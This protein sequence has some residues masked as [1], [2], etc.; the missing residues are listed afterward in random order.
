MSAAQ[1]LE[2]LADPAL[3]Q[4]VRTT[5]LVSDRELGRLARHEHWIESGSRRTGYHP[6]I[7]H[8]LCQSGRQGEARP[9]LAAA[10]AHPSLRAGFARRVFLALLA[11]TA[12][13]L[14]AIDSARPLLAWIRAEL[15][16]GRC[17]IVGPNGYFGALDRYLGLLALTI[18]DA[19]AAV[20]H[21][22]AALRLHQQ[23]RAHG[24]AARSHYDLARALLARRHPG[25]GELAAHHL[26]RAQ[27][28]ADELA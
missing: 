23:M 25:D 22:Q 10:V 14:Q 7:S 20:R 16:Y 5:E 2:R 11:E 6:L 3:L 1:R 24:W 13:A 15:R 28:L 27:T 21:H 19:A 12:F 9:H 26:D 4:F 17:V 8:V 18:G